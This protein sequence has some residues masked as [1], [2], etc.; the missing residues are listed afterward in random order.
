[1]DATITF[2]MDR[3]LRARVGRRMLRRTYPGLALRVL[4]TL[5]V[6]LPL[7]VGVLYLLKLPPGRILFLCGT[8]LVCTSLGVVPIYFR[9]ARKAGQA[10]DRFGEFDMTYRLTDAGLE[11]RSPYAEAVYPWNVF[12]RLARFRDAW[13]LYSDAVNCHVFP[14]EN[15]TDQVRAF[16]EAKVRDAGGKVK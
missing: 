14:A 1:M 13:L 9:A 2:R 4:A 7:T 6:I 5:V 11:T 3:D 8:I 15:L 16:P 10:G 12:V